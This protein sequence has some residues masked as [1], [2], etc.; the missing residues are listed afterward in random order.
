M[1]TKRRNLMSTKKNLEEDGSAGIDEPSSSDFESVERS[2]EIP[3]HDQVLRDE[4]ADVIQQVIQKKLGRRSRVVFK[5]VDD[6][7]L[8][9][10]TG[11]CIFTYPYLDLDK[12]SPGLY[13]SGVME[14]P[15]FLDISVIADE[16]VHTSQDFHHHFAEG[17]S[18]NGYSAEGIP[19]YE[20]YFGS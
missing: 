5:L 3:D 2:V 17:F 9:A 10:V 20:L 4:Q 14:N 18:P 6:L 7:N 1:I 8:V 11:R 16:A 13:R 12:W 19:I 15:T